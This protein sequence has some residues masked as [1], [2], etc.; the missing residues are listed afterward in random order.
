MLRH[1]AGYGL[2]GRGVDTRTLRVFMGHRSIS[3][4]AVYAAIA[5]KRILSVWQTR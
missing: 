2:A 5:D 4:A 3:N 1:S